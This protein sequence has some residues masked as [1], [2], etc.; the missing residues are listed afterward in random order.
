MTV[1]CYYHPDREAINKCE[2]CGK[3]LCVECKQVLHRTYSRGSYSSQGRYSHSHYYSINYD[4]CPECYYDAQIAA[5]S[6]K[7]CIISFVILAVFASIMM[8]MMIGVDVMINSI[9]PGFSNFSM[10]TPGMFIFIPILIIVVGGVIIF[11]IAF[12]SYP[13]KRQQFISEKEEFLKSI[14]LENY[15]PPRT[16]SSGS[17]YQINNVNICPN[18]GEKIEPDDKFCNECGN[19]LH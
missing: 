16:E 18:C 13:K 7:M 10:P 6:P 2:N 14:G 15:N 9:T 3:L 12:I 1:N 4:L 11:Y 19:K 5:T 17:E 8:G